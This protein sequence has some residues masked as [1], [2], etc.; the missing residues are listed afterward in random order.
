MRRLVPQTT[1]GLATLIGIALCGLMLATG[2]LARH[3]A[4]EELEQQLDHRIQAETSLLLT[5]HA[6]GGLPALASAVDA[7]QALHQ[8]VGMG[9]LLV[10]AQ[11]RRLAG[12]LAAQVPAP[13][14]IE[15]LARDDGS[16]GTE[17]QALTSALP[18]G[19]RLVV[20]ADR[21]PIES[22]DGV[23]SSIIAATTLIMLLTGCGGAW[24]L[25]WLVQRRIAR[26]NDVADAIIA[27]DLARRI[28]AGP[29]S[30]EFDRLADTLNRMLDRNADLMANLRQVSTDIAHDLRTP[31]SR[32][33]QM[34]ELALSEAGD[35]ASY[36][37]TI[38]RAAAA[39]DDILQIFSALLRISEIESRAIR[40]SFA[41]LD[42]SELSHRVADAFRPDVEAGGRRLRTRIAAGIMVRGDRHLLSQLLVNLLE[43]AMRHTPAGSHIDVGLAAQDGC[44]ELR[45]DDDGPGIPPTEHARVLQRFTRL[46]GSRSGSGHGLGLSLVKAIADTH[47]A[48]LL[49]EDRA[50]GLRV[51]LRL[52]EHR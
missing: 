32:Q 31:L 26:I 25:G 23:L 14:W 28:P 51:R 39:S 35:A 10:D 34:L 21:T 29:R 11:Q 27:G 5:E 13:G 2:F 6:R 3:L 47:D 22:M 36:R 46:E 49:L 15:H 41:P 4:H 19:S 7:R 37:E 48:T 44:V 20:A 40:H 17:A 52:H 38:Q 8:G 33:K 24:L 30:G 43:N 50:P 12:T 45:V 16:G 1:F 18:D 9:Y 42:L